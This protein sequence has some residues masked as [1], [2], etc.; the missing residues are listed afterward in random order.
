[1]WKN[2]KY[3]E[4]NIL[5]NG[6]AKDGLTLHLQNNSSSLEMI[7]KEKLHLKCL[8]RSCKTCKYK[9]IKIIVQIKHN[10]EILGNPWNSR[11]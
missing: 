3:S 2:K 7:F 9:L 11:T 1:M 5:E 6:R 8:L 4:K 10:H